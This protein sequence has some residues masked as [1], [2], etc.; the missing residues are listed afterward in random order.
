MQIQIKNPTSVTCEY[1]FKFVYTDLH[2]QQQTLTQEMGSKGP[3]TWSSVAPGERRSHDVPDVPR[4]NAESW[5]DEAGNISSD[6]LIE[7]VR[8]PAKE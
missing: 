6:H 5:K 8:K 2:G 7:F 4:R 3:E 1:E